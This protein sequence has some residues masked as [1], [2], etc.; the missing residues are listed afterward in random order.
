[1]RVV[2]VSQWDRGVGSRC[3][4]AAH[5]LQMLCVCTDGA[6]S[7]GV[8]AV[9]MQWPLLR[10]AVVHAR[11]PTPVEPRGSQQHDDTQF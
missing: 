3:H 1:M 10:C 6:A 5:D 4:Y 8:H 9:A 7:P 11:A 2:G